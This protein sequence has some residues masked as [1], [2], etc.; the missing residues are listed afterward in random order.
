[1]RQ[2]EHAKAAGARCA[3]IAEAKRQR[4]GCKRTQNSSGVKKPA[5]DHAAKG[6]SKH[7][8]GERQ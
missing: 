8:H 6:K 5:H 3:E 2:R 4:A 7:H 1:M